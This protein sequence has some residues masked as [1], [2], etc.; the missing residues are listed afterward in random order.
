M[1]GRQQV[2]IAKPTGLVF[3]VD[4]LELNILTQAELAKIRAMY[5]IPNSVVIRIPRPLESLRS[6]ECEVVFFINVFKLGLRL[7]LRH[8]VQKILAQIGY[9]PGYFNPNFWITLLGTITAFG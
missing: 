2:S 7:P 3:G 9:A 1:T 4:F 6:P 5:N 8:S